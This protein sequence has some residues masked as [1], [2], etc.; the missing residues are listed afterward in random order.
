MEI[1]KGKFLIIIRLLINAKE[2]D[3]LYLNLILPFSQHKFIF[4]VWLF[5]IHTEITL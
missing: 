4:A 5:Y 3:I 2:I 1:E